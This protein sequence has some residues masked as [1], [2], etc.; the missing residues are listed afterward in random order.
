MP[1]PESTYEIWLALGN[2][3]TKEDFLNSLKGEKGTAGNDGEQGEAGQAA[4]ITALT[5]NMLP[6]DA[7]PKVHMGGTPQART[8]DIWIPRG[9]KGIPGDINT[10]KPQP[11]ET[12]TCNIEDLQYTIDNLP[13]FLNKNMLT[14]KVNPGT[15]D[16]DIKIDDFCGYGQLWI[17][18][19]STTPTTHN[20]RSIS[21]THYAGTSNIWIFGFN[22]TATTGSGFLVSECNGPVVFSNNNITGG[23]PSDTSNIGISIGV[24]QKIVASNILISNKYRAFSAIYHSHLRTHNITGSNNALGYYVQHASMITKCDQSPLTANTLNVMTNGSLIVN[25]SGGTIG[26]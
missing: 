9:E 5:V 16:A 17:I 21:T 10:P 26:S 6:P 20:V 18:G 7:E 19:N 25:P 1:Q 24:S 14:I 12:I 3:G 11:D 23:I 15:I 22:L 8:F 13:K 4:E 2:T